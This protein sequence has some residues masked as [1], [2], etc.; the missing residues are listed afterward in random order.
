MPEVAFVRELAAIPVA[1]VA[2]YF[3]FKISTNHMHRLADAIDRLTDLLRE[4]L[5]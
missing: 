1:I 2:M 5:R 3:M 4:K